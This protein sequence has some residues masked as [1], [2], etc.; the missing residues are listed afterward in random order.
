MNPG[1]YVAVAEREPDEFEFAER[2][3]E[4]NEELDVLNAEGRQ[5]EERITQAV[6]ALLET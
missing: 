4:L 2:L 1:R 6:E 3:E 5:L